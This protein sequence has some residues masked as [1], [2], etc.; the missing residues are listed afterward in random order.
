MKVSGPVL[1]LT[2]VNPDGVFLVSMVD[3]KLFDT[4]EYLARKIR[5]I[6]APFGEIQL[7]ICGDFFQLPPVVKNGD[8]MTFAFDAFTWRKCIHKQVTLTKVFRQKESG[9]QSTFFLMA[10]LSTHRDQSSSQFS[11]NC[12]LVKSVKRRLRSSCRYHDRCNTTTVSSQLRCTR[13]QV[14]LWGSDVIV[15]FSRRA[16]VD[17][18]NQARLKQLPGEEASYRA[19]DYPGYDSK[20]HPTSHQRMV[21]LL[22]QT[23]AVPLLTLRVGAQ[24]MLIKVS[25]QYSIPELNQ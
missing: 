22:D 24:V 5:R 17:R 14:R 25:N 15:S 6:D 16:E 2:Q 9:Q 18:A 4:L 20:G 3:G 23:R 11:T 13:P 19:S 10:F 1:T 21:Q 7:V 8:R 12:G